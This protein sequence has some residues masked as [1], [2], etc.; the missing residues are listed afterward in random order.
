MNLSPYNTALILMGGQ[1]ERFG[2]SLPKQ[3]H[4]L[5][6]KPVYLHTLETFIASDLFEEI[7]L[8]TPSSWM[9]AV[10]QEI[11]SYNDL[12]IRVV[13]GGATRQESSRKGLLCCSPQTHIVVIHDAVRPFVSKTIL[14]DNVE[15][16]LQKRAVDTCIPSSDTLVYAPDIRSICAI[17]KRSDYLRGQTPQSFA[18]PLILKAHEKALEEGIFNSSD[19]CSLVLRLGHPISIVFGNEENLKIT[20]ELDLN[21]A[22]QL[23]KL[24]RHTLEK[25][26][27]E[28]S[29]QGKKFA[30]TGGT[31]GIGK[32]IASLLEKEGAL[33]F[34][35]SRSSPLY[36][37][38]LTS[39][40]KTR[41]VFETLLQEH[42][43]L[44]GLINS[45]GQL[46]T[47]PFQTL[48]E[49]EI[50]SQ[51]A[52]N[53]TSVMY[54][55]KWAQLKPGAHIINIAS[56]SHIR[57]RENYAVYSSAKAGL[58]NFTQGLAEERKDLYINALVPQRTH[59]P[60][61]LDNFP[62][63]DP[64]HLLD[65][66]IVAQETLLLLK[67]TSLSGELIE[68]RKHLE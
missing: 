54:S 8:V 51:I 3:F 60:M 22:E 61:R 2:S 52:S 27:Q 29:L 36:P 32:A 43:P 28:R 34:C 40:E 49:D 4:R 66:L 21:F 5:S 9:Q 17:P 64:S 58:V 10:E 23:L 39:F 37:A 47:A 25:S 53:L 19:D 63:E 67:Q 14:K 33:C 48:T 45:I 26:L 15:G 46:K 11:K 7:L 44:D 20:S 35:I 57:G 31:G 56:S 55:C 13:E 30:L 16:A 41:A 42:G 1:G 24:K 12:S 62:E 68:V 38:D 18:Y 59:T 6:G 50:N 65:P